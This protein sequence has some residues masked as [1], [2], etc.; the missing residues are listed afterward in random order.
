MNS[1]WRWRRFPEDEFFLVSDQPF[2]MPR[3]A[4]PNLRARRRT[5]Q[6][7]RTPLVALGLARELRRLPA[8]LFHGTDFAVPYIPARPSVLTLH[9]LSPWMDADGMPMPPAC[10][11]ALRSC[12]EWAWPPWS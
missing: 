12:S 4:P 3:D 6:R 5:A 2:A 1:A 8:D 10:A 11:G 7:A 9:D